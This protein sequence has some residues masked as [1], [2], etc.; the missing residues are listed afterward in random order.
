MQEILEKTVEGK[1]DLVTLIDLFLGIGELV[2]YIASIFIFIQGAPCSHCLNF[3]ELQSLLDGKNTDF[4]ILY[5]SRGEAQPIVD[6]CTPHH[7]VKRLDVTVRHTS[8]CTSHLYNTSS[9]S[10][11]HHDR[12]TLT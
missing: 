10:I 4:V 6:E 2:C 3:Y 5:Q 12:L 9:A 8:Q 1:Q 7:V 11:Y